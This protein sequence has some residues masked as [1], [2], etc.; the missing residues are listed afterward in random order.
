MR[1]RLVA[2]EVAEA[3]VAIPV[4]HRKPE[5]A[6]SAFLG[7]ALMAR[8][9]LGRGR[10]PASGAPEGKTVAPLTAAP[11]AIYTKETT[12]A[13]AVGTVLAGLVEQSA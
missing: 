8:P 10:L 13:V 1:Q 11:I 12:E 7:R 6:A 3:L 4:G 5:G 9:E 2:A